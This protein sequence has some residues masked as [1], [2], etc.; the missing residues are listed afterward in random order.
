MRCNRC[1]VGMGT[2]PGGMW[3][4]R[5]GGG[6]KGKPVRKGRGWENTLGPSEWPK[7]ELEQGGGNMLEA[8]MAG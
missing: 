5:E 7:E 3:E 4:Q 2:S 6:R 8:G 1:S